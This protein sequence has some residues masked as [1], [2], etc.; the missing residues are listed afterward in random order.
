MTLVI[1]EMFGS[2]SLRSELRALLADAEREAAG[3]DGCL[4]YTVASTLADPDRYLVVEEWRDE[5]ALEAHYASPEFQRF[6]FALHGLL[7]RSSDAKIHTVAAT[8]RPAASGPIDP[9]DAD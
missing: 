7:V 5:A 9:R 6:Q 1:A 2:V 3:H 4:R 8:V